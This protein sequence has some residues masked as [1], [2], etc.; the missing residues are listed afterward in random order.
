MSDDSVPVNPPTPPRP[1]EGEGAFQ[2]IIEDFEDIDL[3]SYF[4]NVES[5]VESGSTQNTKEYDKHNKLNGDIHK[6]RDICVPHPLNDPNDRT[7][8]P[9]FT[10]WGGVPTKREEMEVMN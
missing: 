7:H 10:T 3:T 4:S 5:D 2:V 9:T 6:Y 8:S 1:R